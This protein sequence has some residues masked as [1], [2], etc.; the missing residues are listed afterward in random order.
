MCESEFD[1]ALREVE[2][3]DIK[4]DRHIDREEFKRQMLQ[5]II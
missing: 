4:K 3:L 2:N 1:K 5:S